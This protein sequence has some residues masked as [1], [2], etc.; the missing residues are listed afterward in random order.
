M[1]GVK[2]AGEHML[3]TKIFK[4]QGQFFLLLKRMQ[5]AALVRR[6]KRK[7]GWRVES[8]EGIIR[9]KKMNGL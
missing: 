5:R 2:R 3:A 7:L 1:T 6:R 4:N 9:L 8:V